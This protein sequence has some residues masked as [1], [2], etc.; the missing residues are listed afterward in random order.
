MRHWIRTTLLTTL[1]VLVLT[2]ASQPLW[3]EDDAPSASPIMAQA[4]DGSSQDAFKESL[5]KVKAEATDQEYA[6]LENALGMMRSYDMAIRSNPDLLAAR[7]NGKSPA[8]V[9]QMV[10]ERWKL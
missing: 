5:A 2:L 7:V 9:V 1:S 4:L 6:Q 8:E 10:K 3:A